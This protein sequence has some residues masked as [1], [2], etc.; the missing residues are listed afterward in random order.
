MTHRPRFSRRRIIHD[1]RKAKR[2]HK[3][4]I[5]LMRGKRQVWVLGEDANDLKAILGGRIKYRD[6]IKIYRFPVEEFRQNLQRI[7]RAGH[8]V[9][10]FART[11]LLRSDPEIGW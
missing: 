6:G 9:V 1:W 2:D 10:I 7:R 4:K 11:Y 8:S 5:I 3:G